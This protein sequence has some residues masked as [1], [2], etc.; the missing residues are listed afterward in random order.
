MTVLSG[1]VVAWHI[2]FTTSRDGK[3]VDNCPNQRLRADARREE[4][5]EF[6]GH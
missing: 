5:G 2:L 6:D 3:G 1:S 4:V